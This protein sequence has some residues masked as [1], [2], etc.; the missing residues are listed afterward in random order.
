MLRYQEYPCIFG[1][2][3]STHHFCR[4]IKTTPQ[5]PLI[6]IKRYSQ[7][8][9]F[10]SAIGSERAYRRQIGAHAKRINL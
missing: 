1:N 7:N 3:K 8:Y 2:S 6:V 10:L 4:N 9:S 5:L